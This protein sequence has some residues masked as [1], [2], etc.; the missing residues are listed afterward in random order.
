MYVA[1]AKPCGC[2]DWEYER[3]RPMD[4]ERKVLRKK[5]Q[6]RQ[7]EKRRKNT[8]RKWE[9]KTETVGGGDKWGRS[10]NIWFSF[11]KTLQKSYFSHRFFI[12]LPPPPKESSSETHEHKEAVAS[13]HCS[14]C[15]TH[16]K[17]YHQSTRTS[18]SSI[19][20]PSLR[21]ATPLGMRKQTTLVSKGTRAVLT[22]VGFDV[23][24]H[25]HVTFIM[26]LHQESLAT[27][28]TAEVGVVAMVLAD[29]TLPA[30]AGFEDGLAPL[31]P[32]HLVRW[33]TL[34]Y[35]TASTS[36][37]MGRSG[38]CHPILTLPL[39][40]TIQGTRLPLFWCLQLTQPIW[41]KDS[42]GCQPVSP[43]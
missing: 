31:T 41:V 13:S 35:T 23:V 1:T 17:T 30:M 43:S 6:S 14:Y 3:Q 29:M 15:K 34:C 10:Q 20:T 42:V 37:Q 7:Q 9:R 11:L 18:A 2:G 36:G 4:F 19:S 22:M 28:L 39:S 24:V 26:A 21:Q 8:Q 5:A 33:E 38:D 40:A 27:H 16:Q 12:P 25:V 32:V